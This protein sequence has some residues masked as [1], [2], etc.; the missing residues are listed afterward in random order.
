[1]GFFT[2]DSD[3]KSLQPHKLFLQ[4][5]LLICSQARDSI[6]NDREMYGCITCENALLYC[7]NKKK[8]AV[9]GTKCWRKMLFYTLPF[10]SMAFLLPLG[11]FT[12]TPL[13]SWQFPLVGAAQ[14]EV[15][16]VL[17]KGFK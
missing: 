6:E 13:S 11:N 5:I 17:S 2:G 15:F 16:V 7:Q 8:K 3:Q 14:L 12:K 9:G 10:F 1:M 4:S